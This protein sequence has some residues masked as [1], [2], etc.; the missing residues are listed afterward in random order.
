MGASSVKRLE[1]FF[2]S[3][4]EISG[5]DERRASFATYAMGILSDAERKSA[6][7][8]AA[9]ACADPERADAGHQRL[10]HRRSR[11]GSW[12]TPAS[13]SKGLTRWACSGK[14]RA[15]PGR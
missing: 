12:T 11:L 7:P 2:G 4:G 8:L 9:R 3:I 1:D 15:R 14:P 10:L 5:N 6:E 13:S